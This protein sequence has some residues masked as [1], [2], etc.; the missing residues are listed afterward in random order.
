LR[1]SSSCAAKTGWYRSSS[2]DLDGSYR[3]RVIAGF[4]L[5][6]EWLWADPLPSLSFLAEIGFDTD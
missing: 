6:G 5:R 1:K 4:R 3:S 2:P